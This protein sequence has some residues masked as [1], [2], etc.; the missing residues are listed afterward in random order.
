MFLLQWVPGLNLGLCSL[1]D[2]WYSPNGWFKDEIVVVLEAFWWT[3]IADWNMGPYWKIYYMFINDY[4]IFLS[5]MIVYGVAYFEKICSTVGLLAPLW[6]NQW[7]FYPWVRSHPTVPMLEYICYYG[8]TANV[9]QKNPW[10]VGLGLKTFPKGHQLHQQT[11][12]CLAS[13]F[14]DTHINLRFFLLKKNDTYLPFF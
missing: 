12:Q 11:V 4:E 8:I 14:W 1:E 13:I 9:L 6:W 10:V 3:N 2:H 5:A 7:N